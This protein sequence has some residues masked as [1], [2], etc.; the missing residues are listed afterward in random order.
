MWARTWDLADV[1]SNAEQVR[2]H[3]FRFDLANY[4]DVF[5][6]NDPLV[7]VVTN[8]LV[9]RTMLSMT[10]NEWN[11]RQLMRDIEAC[12]SNLSHLVRYAYGCNFEAELRSF[13]GSVP[14][15][16][17]DGL[18]STAEPPP[19]RAEPASLDADK[20]GILL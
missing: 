9:Q 7:P 18:A 8:H 15:P 3:A 19:T 13:L 2:L 20:A 12:K 14:G 16:P 4:I 6:Q 1:H 5:L 10:E 11:A 17:R